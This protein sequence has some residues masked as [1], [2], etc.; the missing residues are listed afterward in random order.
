M[1]ENLQEFNQ[2][3]KVRDVVGLHKFIRKSLG[4]MSAFQFPLYNAPT[5]Y[6][7]SRSKSSTVHTQIS[8]ISHSV[9]L[10]L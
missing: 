6:H 1:Y 9:L 10:T 5:V 8:L 3:N 4:S 7:Q 2:E